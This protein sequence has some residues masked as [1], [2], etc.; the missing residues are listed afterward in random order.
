MSAAD[1]VAVYDLPFVGV[2]EQIY[3]W[4]REVLELRH[5]AAGD[6][7]GRLSGPSGDGPGEVR[8]YL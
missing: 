1:D 4:V 8:R 7:E 6:P 5:G 3:A 2:E